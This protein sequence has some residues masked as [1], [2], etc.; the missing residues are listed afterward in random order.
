MGD[1]AP[2]NIQPEIDRSDNRAE[3]ANIDLEEN[4][5]D[6][7]VLPSRNVSVVS[8]QNRLESASVDVLNPVSS[9]GEWKS[10]CVLEVN[11]DQSLIQGIV[12]SIP[13]NLNL[14][15]SSDSRVLLKAQN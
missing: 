6:L 10:S 7:D 5:L 2:V 12:Y 4:R 8:G 11:P 15:P 9:E 1:P 13:D 3:E 14:N